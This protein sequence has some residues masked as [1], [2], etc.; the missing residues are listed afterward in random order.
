MPFH[1]LKG[2]FVKKFRGNEMKTE[3]KSLRCP[4]CGAQA[5]KFDALLKE[6]EARTAK[7]AALES[8]VMLARGVKK[9]QTKEKL[10]D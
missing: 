6:S 1:K 9:P 4:H 5:G 10:D 8:Y 7:L 3:N 2:L